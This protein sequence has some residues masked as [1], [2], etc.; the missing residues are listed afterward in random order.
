MRGLINTA[1]MF[2]GDGSIDA[3]SFV[4]YVVFWDEGSSAVTSVGVFGDE[5]NSTVTMPCSDRAGE[6]GRSAGT[7][8]V[9]G[10]SPRHDGFS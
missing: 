10:D 8:G 2:W 4:S 7:Y 6:I 1:L 3:A 5:G 9:T